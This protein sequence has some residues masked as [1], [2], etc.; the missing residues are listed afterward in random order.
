M[1]WVGASST[2]RWAPGVSV[3]RMTAAATV[4]RLRPPRVR[5]GRT[6]DFALGSL[7]GTLTITELADGR[8]GEIFIRTAKQGSTLAGLCETISIATSL[9]LQ[10]HTPVIDVVQR[11]LHTRFE[12]SGHTSDPEVPVASSLTDYLARRL[13]MDYLTPDE[14]KQLEVAGPNPTSSMAPVQRQTKHHASSR[15]DDH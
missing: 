10:H 1:L 9:A 3:K 15:I 14:L 12:P 2:T 8:P 13:A 6:Y 4:T 11:M 7:T 5:R